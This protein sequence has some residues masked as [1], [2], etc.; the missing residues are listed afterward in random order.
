MQ[1]LERGTKGKRFLDG[2]FLMMM[3]LVVLV[4]GLTWEV[5]NPLPFLG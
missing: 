3:V 1:G 4:F 2:L 5:R